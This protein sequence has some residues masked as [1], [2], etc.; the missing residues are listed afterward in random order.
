MSTRFILSL[1]AVVIITGI[2]LRIMFHFHRERGPRDSV[3]TKPSEFALHEIAEL[4]NQSIQLKLISLSD[5]CLGASL[6]FI[7]NGTD[8]LNFRRTC[9]RFNRIYRQYK[10]RQNARFHNFEMMFQIPNDTQRTKCEWQHCLHD[11]LYSVITAPMVSDVLVDFSTLEQN[12]TN[13]TY[14]A[15]IRSLM[16][17]HRRTRTNVLRGLYA[18]GKDKNAFLSILL[19]NDRNWE[20]DPLLLVTWC[21]NKTLSSAVCQR[22]QLPWH[23]QNFNVTALKVLLLSRCMLIQDATRGTHTL[24]TME[25]RRCFAHLRQRVYANG[26]DL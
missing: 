17:L 14:P 21:Q 19:W 11:V 9:M 24:W 10:V 4:T 7:R 23:P 26:L 20:M 22:Y 12:R 13:F 16:A 25:R 15:D 8:L 3:S 2:S 18:V 1:L 5:D 6:E